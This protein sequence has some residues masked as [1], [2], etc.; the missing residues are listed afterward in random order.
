MIIIYLLVINIL[1]YLIMFLD[2]KRAREKKWRIK[3][4]NIFFLAILGG[5][6]GE[7]L[8]M[9]RFRHKTKHWYFKYG[10]PI[11]LIIQLNFLFY[12]HYR[13]LLIN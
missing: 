5:S 7:T 8:G 9:Y 10:L 4:K 13:K 3:E 11:I 12:L 6:L 2:K 1:G